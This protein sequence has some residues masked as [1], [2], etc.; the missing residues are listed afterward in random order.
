[1]NH[2]IVIPENIMQVYNLEPDINNPTF[3]SKRKGSLVDDIHR[4]V[5]RHHR[6]I[7]DVVNNPNGIVFDVRELLYTR[8]SKY[9]VDDLIAH[10]IVFN[11]V[12][13]VKTLLQLDLN[14][15]A[16]VNSEH[17]NRVIKSIDHKQVEKFKKKGLPV[18][19]I[20][21][22][23]ETPAVYMIVKEPFY[24]SDLT[25]LVYEDL[26][27]NIYPLFGESRTLAS[28]LFYNFNK[29]IYYDV[30]RNDIRPDI[31]SKQ[32]N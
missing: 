6:N 18:T 3:Y 4:I 10:N 25:R 32:G 2:V 16:Y 20:G 9:D 31:N 8:L 15:M 5:I 30:S 23:T 17:V 7:R 27:F 14:G 26:L 22:D 19:Y 24:N 11:S 13:K 21:L 29:E 1:M 28:G 12:F